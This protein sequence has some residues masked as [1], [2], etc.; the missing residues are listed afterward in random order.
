MEKNKHTGM[1]YFSS[2]EKDKIRIQEQKHEAFLKKQ[3]SD[4]GIIVDFDTI[5]HHGFR[6]I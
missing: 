4:L 6:N 1:H 5:Q 3:L 2:S